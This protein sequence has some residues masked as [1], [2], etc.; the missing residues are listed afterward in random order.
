MWSLRFYQGSLESLATITISYY[1]WGKVLALWQLAT[2]QLGLPASP[3]F[4]LGINEDD[5]HVLA[6][7]CSASWSSSSFSVRY[8]SKIPEIVKGIL[9][10][11]LVPKQLILWCVVHC[12]CV[13][14]WRITQSAWLEV[15]D[16]RLWRFRTNTCAFSSFIIRINKGW[17]T[18]SR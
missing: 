16:R 14:G 10:E 8:P 7:G 15:S 12:L 6:N 9:L 18:L 17:T 5:V 4:C 11:I 13:I 3:S 2:T 1:L